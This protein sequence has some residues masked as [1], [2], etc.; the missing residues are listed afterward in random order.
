MQLVAQLVLEQQ[1][2]Q[3]DQDLLHVLLVV[4]LV[5]ELVLV[6][7]VELTDLRV[8]LLDA[9]ERV[10]GDV[11]EVA[12]QI[13]NLVHHRKR[14]LLLAEAVDQRREPLLQTQVLARAWLQ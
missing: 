6:V 3:V 1:L 4:V 7:V 13:L 14:S 12:H 11:R 10:G 8:L 9:L 2:L 5:R